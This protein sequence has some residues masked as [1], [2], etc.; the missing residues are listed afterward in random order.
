MASTSS[1][2]PSPPP[3]SDAQPLAVGGSTCQCY[4]VR[5][6]GKL[7]F[8]KQLKPGL[9]TNPHYAAALQ[10]EFETGYGLEHP[11][12]V[13]Y[14]SRTADSIL[15]DYVDGLP[16]DQFLTEQPHYFR[17]RRAAD[18]FLR[19]L[20]SVVGYLHQHQIV[21]LDLKPQNILITR[22]DHDVKLID[23]G[24]CYTDT[25]TDTMGRTDKYAAPE[26]LPGGTGQVDARTD[27]Y[28]IG[29]LV[30]SLPCAPIYNKVAARCT[31][32]LPAD[33]YQN[34]E[35]LAAALGTGSRAAH[36]PLWAAAVAVPAIAGLL[37][38]HTTE[39]GS[40]A[41][42]QNH[43]DSTPRYE[44]RTTVPAHQDAA[45]AHQDTAV[46]QTAAAPAPPRASSFPTPQS[47]S[48]APQPSPALAEDTLALRRELQAAI[49]PRFEEALGH[50]SDSVYYRIH[51]E[52]YSQLWIDFE[53][54]LLPLY[55]QLWQKY[56]DK[57]SKHTMESE[58]CQTIQY[59]RLT[60]FWQMMRNDPDHDPFYDGKEFRYYDFGC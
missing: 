56:Q 4:R 43:E 45:P 16:L 27:I 10:K 7:H 32:T 57:V 9:A 34:T 17:S 40:E 23:L 13:R 50:Y 19:Q 14:V 30:Q 31:A 12:L 21:H 49:G 60:Q 52:H 54:S 20:L 55:R 8:L 37:L 48:P 42:S 59:Y 11:H 36:W 15:M 26:Q 53:E 18:R 44:E 33:R 46:S 3:Y 25:Y 2:T 58:W 1:F 28:A 29:R 39:K 22:I 41:D 38:W 47:S 51:Q 35:E 24:Y 6:Y 5:L